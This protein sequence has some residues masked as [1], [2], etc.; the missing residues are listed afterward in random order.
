[1][2]LINFKK[3]IC[4]IFTLVFIL[5]VISQAQ[6]TASV[7]SINS[8]LVTSSIGVKQ[9]NRVII[10]GGQGT[11]QAT[12]LYLFCNI[13]AVP[14]WLKRINYDES[15]GM[16]AGWDSLL[17]ENSCSVLMLNRKAME[18]SCGLVNTELPTAA[19]CSIYVNAT[20]IAKQ[21]NTFSCANIGNYWVVESWTKEALGSERESLQQMLVKRGI[22]VK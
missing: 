13:S 1:M 12:Q 14:L 16:Q 19:D 8:S 17:A 2:K 21:E 18:F 7:T 22:F 6:A 10:L 3:N 4:K 11:D 9:N 15:R 5:L 20:R